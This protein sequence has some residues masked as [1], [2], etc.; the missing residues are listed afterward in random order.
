LKEINIKNIKKFEIK[1]AFEFAKEATILAMMNHQNI[2]KY[3]DS[4]FD[5]NSSLFYIVTELC[6]VI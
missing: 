5:D 2:I 3:Y 1:D 6:E 4:F